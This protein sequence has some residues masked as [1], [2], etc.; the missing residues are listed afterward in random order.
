M[1]ATYQ[2]EVSIRSGGTQDIVRVA[3]DLHT[4]AFVDGHP[5]RGDLGLVHPQRKLLA[6]ARLAG[7]PIPRGIRQAHGDARHGRGPVPCTD[8]ER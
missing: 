8:R 5:R 1:A 4:E 7:C 2:E 6:V 3:L